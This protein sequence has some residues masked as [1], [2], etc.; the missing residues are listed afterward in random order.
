MSAVSLCIPRYWNVA[1][2][3][4][5]LTTR[6]QHVE[7]GHILLGSP[8]LSSARRDGLARN[9]DA[10]KRITNS[11]DNGYA[12]VTKDDANDPHACLCGKSGCGLSAF[13]PFYHFGQAGW[14]R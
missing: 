8:Q 11:V 1:F 2:S 6:I 14:T 5:P 13:C 7:A 10:E 12:D 4:A 3:F 9:D